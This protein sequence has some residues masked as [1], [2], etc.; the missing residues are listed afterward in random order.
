M[1]HSRRFL[2]ELITHRETETDDRWS[3]GSFVVYDAP[4]GRMTTTAAVNLLVA[5][6][7]GST[8]V[9][10]A[11]EEQVTAG[12]TGFGLTIKFR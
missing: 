5:L 8:Q 1:L 2:Q 7:S 6:V 10:D 4:Q 9:Q 12:S 11:E 3:T